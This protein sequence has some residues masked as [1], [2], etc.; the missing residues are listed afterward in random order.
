MNQKKDL[1]LHNHN[2][3]LKKMNLQNNKKFRVLIIIV[4]QF[5]NYF[6]SKNKIGK[7]MLKMN[8]FYLI[9]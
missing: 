9:E 2:I 3:L 7:E 8:F 5:I 1:N 4:I 6:Q